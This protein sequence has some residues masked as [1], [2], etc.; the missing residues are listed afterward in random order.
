MSDRSLNDSD[1][2]MFDLFQ[3]L[4]STIDGRLDVLAMILGT[5]AF[6]LLPL[7]LFRRYRAGQLTWALGKEMF[8]NLSPLIPTILTGGIATAFIIGLFSTAA[9][10]APWQLPVNIW[11]T[12]AA[13]V[14]VDFVYYIDHRIGHRV[15]L[16]WAFSHSVH[17]SSPIFNQTTAVRISFVDGFISPWYYTLIILI[18]FDPLLVA[19]AFGFNLAYQQW[20]H[21]ETIGKLGWFDRWFNS[22][23]NHRVHHASQTQ[24]L[25][26]N[27]GGI[28]M[29]W[30]RMFGTYEAEGEAV[31][32]GLTHPINSVNP[33]KVHFEEFTRLIR[34]MGTLRTFRARVRLLFT[35]PDVA[36]VD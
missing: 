2:T 20:I 16:L 11:T 6:L 33:W 25:D 30:D 18:G 15:R 17:H 1:K 9:S 7:E 34:K 5:A 8:A 3:E 24:Y 13:I 32:Y 12:L 23:S 35:A 19:A 27:Y 28:L 22:P 21:T 14:L 36:V 4:P 10:L 26:K 31:V 29:I